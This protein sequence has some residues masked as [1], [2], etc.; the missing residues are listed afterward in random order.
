MHITQLPKLYLTS[1]LIGLGCSLGF[2]IFKGPAP[3]TVLN[4]GQ[5]PEKPVLQIKRLRLGREAA[6]SGPKAVSPHNLPPAA[7]WGPRPSAAAHPTSGAGAP[8]DAL[9]RSAPHA[10]SCPARAPAPSRPL[11]TSKMAAG[12]ADQVRGPLA[13]VHGGFADTKIPSSLPSRLRLALGEGRGRRRRSR[14]RGGRANKPEEGLRG[15]RRTL[16]AAAARRETA[17]QA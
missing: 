2:G 15:E 11:A 6:S 5:L 7:R 1:G 3:G 4:K 9:R 12:G 13:G 10:W 16:K 8:I 17:A 14:A